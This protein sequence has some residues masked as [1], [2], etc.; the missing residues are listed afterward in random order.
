MA[1]SVKESVTEA[2]LGSTEE[3]NLSEQA[4]AIFYRHAVKDENG[5]HYLGKEQFIDAVAPASEDYHK[6]KRDQYA[7]LFLVADRKK[8]GRVTLHDWTN[9]DNLVAKPDAEYEIAFRLFDVEGTGLINF[10]DFER[11]YNAHKGEDSLPFDWNSEWASL[12][13]GA[14]NKRHAMTYPQFSQMLRGLQGEKVRQAFMHFDKNHD[15]YIEP[16]QFQRIII[17]TAGHKLSDH[18]LENLHTLCNIS[19]GTKISYANVR[20]FQNMIREMDLVE[21]IIR[22]ASLKSSD[23]RITRTDFLNEAARITRFSLF[24][25][26][27][28][29]ILFHFAGLDEP[30]GRLSINDFAKVLDPSWHT[31]YPS[32]ADLVSDAGAKAFTKTK[33]FF[34]D[35]LES[36][37][38]FALG[39]IAGAFGAFMV[40]PIDMVKTRMQNQRSQRVGERLYNNS[41]DCFKKIVRN[42]GFRGL[43]AGVLPQ[44]VGVAPEKAIKLTVNDLV[45]GKFTDKKTGHIWWGWEVLAGGSAGGCQVIF[46]N[47]LEIVKIRLQVQGEIAKSVDGA[48]RRSAMWII[49]NLGLVG[50]YKGASA[51]LLRDVP[52]SAI[53]FPTYSHLKRDYFGESPTK[54][55]GV[56]QLLTA[57]AIAGM[58]AAYLT[59]PADVIKTRL[60][61]EA[62]KG[63][64]TYRGLTHCAR[65]IWQQ[66]GFRAFFKGGPAR[67]FR[68]SPQFG[69]TLAGY[70][71]LQNMLPMPGSGHGEG[72]RGHV[73]PAVG[74]H[75]ATAPLPYLRSRNALKIILDLDENFGRPKLPAGKKWEGFPGFGGKIVGA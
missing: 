62:R 53:Y 12:Y 72:V 51:C 32:G 63:E 30:S 11:V 68:S 35:V 57:G 52:F 26:M 34:H 4:K 46:T 54:K 14:K 64:A 33:T 25:P 22:N 36:A 2:L 16:E 21:L 24:T 3:P 74:L 45:R 44:L 42:E 73:E 71:V 1:A 49:R 70:E 15:G 66:E 39:S 65:M 29:D 9:F 61:V 28:A 56:F 69:F 23:G 10:A 43:Y 19:A 8:T 58:P 13:I 59:T 48:P 55:L 20:A 27:E 40:Y 67:I 75:E 47:P 31:Q 18:L 17:D 6:I 50:L 41:I 7:I 38:H 5:Q 60:Q 37:H